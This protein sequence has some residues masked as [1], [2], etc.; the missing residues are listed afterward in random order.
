MM[1]DNQYELVKHYINTQQ[2][3]TIKIYD[4]YL[5]FHRNIIQHSNNHEL[6]L[7][8]N[9]KKKFFSFNDLLFFV[10]LPPAII[11][12]IFGSNPLSIIDV[13]STCHVDPS[14]YDIIIF[15]DKSAIY[16]RTKISSKN[17]K[18]CLN[19][20]KILPY[21]VHE[22]LELLKCCGMSNED[23]DLFVKKLD[24]DEQIEV[25]YSNK[26][27]HILQKIIDFTDISTRLK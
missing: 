9:S 19:K 2:Y 25:F 12:K 13:T 24:K 11:K 4:C 15:A 7:G 5:L 21:Y 23:I 14:L 1:S 27:D 26:Y 10:E 17:E 22:D 3:L 6:G 8:T 18:D 20:W 16:T